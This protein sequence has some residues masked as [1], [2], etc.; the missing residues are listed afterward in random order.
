M[1]LPLLFWQAYFL[2]LFVPRSF[3]SSLPSTLLYEK[4]AIPQKYPLWWLYWQNLIKGKIRR[5]SCRPEE[6]IMTTSRWILR[7]S[8]FSDMV[9]HSQTSIPSH[10]HSPWNTGYAQKRLSREIVAEKGHLPTRG[11][12]E[13]PPFGQAVRANQVRLVA[14]NVLQE[15]SE[16]SALYWGPNVA[17]CLVVLQSDHPSLPLEVVVHRVVEVE[18]VQDGRETPH[19]SGV[20]NISNC[21]I[22]SLMEGVSRGVWDF[23]YQATQDS[24][25]QSHQHCWVPKNN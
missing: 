13:V 15:F 24:T 4:S 8:I 16:C 19:S 18:V 25:Q 17:K 20:L 1:I 11:Q 22:I 5:E 3:S 21:F 7:I 2:L 12:L 14:G 23:S 9:N 6:M 10:P